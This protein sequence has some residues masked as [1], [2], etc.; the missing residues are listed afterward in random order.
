MKKPTAIDTGD[1]GSPTVLSVSQNGADDGRLERIFRESALTHYTNS[2]WTL[3]TRP[4]LPSS[5]SVLRETPISIVLCESELFPGTWREVL[6]Q[7]QLLPDPPLLIV[8]SRLADEHLWAEALN[9]GAYDVLT[10]PFDARE[11]IRV[12]NA[13]R[14]YWQHRH[15]LHAGRTKQMK[16]G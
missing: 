12:L 6:E 10:K 5:V 2:E 11:V 13:A 7:I 8:T 9:L 4:T 16:A 15:Q 1:T 3:V 14:H